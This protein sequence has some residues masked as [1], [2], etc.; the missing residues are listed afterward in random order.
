MSDRESLLVGLF[1]ASRKGEFAAVDPT[2]ERLLGR[3]LM[4]LRDVLAAR[5]S[6]GLTKRGTHAL[7]A[8]GSPEPSPSLRVNMAFVI[9]PGEDC[10]K[11][12]AS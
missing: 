12:G 4:S 6:E 3:P 2:L 9:V 1:A 10:Q 7:A 8:N 5:L 11:V